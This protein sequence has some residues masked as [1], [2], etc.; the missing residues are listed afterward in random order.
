MVR[1]RLEKRKKLR[2]MAWK[3]TFIYIY[4]YSYSSEPKEIMTIYNPTK[5]ED[6]WWQDIKR[7]RNIKEGKITWN[8]FKR[9]F[10]KQYLSE[11]Y[12]EGKSK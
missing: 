11:Q 5:K 1:L 8:T 9:Y 12:Y 3:K 6:I 2:F 7:V 4:I 10:K